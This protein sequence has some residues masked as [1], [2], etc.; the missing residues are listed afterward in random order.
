MHVAINFRNSRRFEEN[1]CY[2][3]QCHE[4]EDFAGKFKSW[5]FLGGKKMPGLC[6]PTDL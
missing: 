2:E 3:K 4:K 6:F 1:Q 5:L